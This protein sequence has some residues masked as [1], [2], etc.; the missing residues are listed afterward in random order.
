MPRAPSESGIAQLDGSDAASHD[1]GPSPR[2]RSRSRLENPVEL[3]A[4]TVLLSP[5]DAGA[6]SGNAAVSG[7]VLLEAGR[8]NAG[9][10]VE[11]VGTRAVAATNEK[12]EFTMRNLPFGEQ[13]FGNSS[14]CWLCCEDFGG[15]S[16]VARRKRVAVKLPKFLETMDPVLV[17]ARRE[18]ALDKVGFL[19]GREPMGYHIGPERS[20]RCTLLFVTDLSGRC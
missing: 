16:L 7:T 3:L 2:P 4:R 9:T 19:S 1:A 10:R 6:K 13:G 18:A 5:L 14:A 15:R 11:L 17:M 12:G 8:T 20:S